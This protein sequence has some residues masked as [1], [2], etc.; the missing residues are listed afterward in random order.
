MANVCRPSDKKDE[1]YVA[2]STVI[3]VSL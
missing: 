3:D 1:M 2:Y